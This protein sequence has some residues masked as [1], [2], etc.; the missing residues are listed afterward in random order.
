MW[1]Y[2]HSV[3]ENPKS[4]YN[5]SATGQWQTAFCVCQRE[6]WECQR[7]CAQSGGQSKNIDWISLMW[8]W[9]SL[10]DCT[11]AISSSTV[12]NDVARSSCLKPIAL[13]VWLAASSSCERYSLTSYGLGMK[14]VCRRTTNQLAERSGLFMH[15]SVPRSD[16][17]I[18]AI[19]YACRLRCSLP[20]HKWV[21][22]KWYLSTLW[23]RWTASELRCLAVSADAS[24]NEACRR[25]L[26]IH[27][28]I[29]CEIG[30]F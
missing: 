23:W 5:W 20:C 9:H 16:T 24:S 26:F 14:T 2:R 25:T 21:W 19:C 4:G 3:K 11:I 12:S 1:K 27:K 10:T 18:L 13:P 29:C 6:H 28:T 7:P 17:S 22:L 15:Q 8:N 30:H